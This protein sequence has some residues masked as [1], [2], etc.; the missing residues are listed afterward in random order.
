MAPGDMVLQPPYIRHRVLES[1]PGLEVV[2]IGC[3]ALHETLADHDMLLPNGKAD[4]A[5]DFEGQ[6]FLHHVAARS[7]WT[8]RHGAE[9]QE[10]GLRAASGGLADARLIRPGTSPSIEMPPH[11]GELVFGFVLE[12]SARLEHGE[13][14][15]LGPADC[16]VIPPARAWRLIEAS[17]D[18]LLL[19]LTTGSMFR[20]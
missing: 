6:S 14:R 19:H 7:P 1:S 10:T 17:R 3:P 4:P 18:F 15:P 8:A 11:D 13:S 9:T 20:S 12:G 16:F 2:E 5:R